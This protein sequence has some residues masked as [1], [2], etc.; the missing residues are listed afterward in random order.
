MSMIQIDWTPDRN[1]LRQFA[2]IWLSGFSLIG[3]LFAWKLGCFEGTQA[4]TIPIGL[5]TAAG[6]VGFLGLAFPTAVKPVYLLWMAVTFPIGWLLS[7]TILAIIYFAIFGV[8]GLVFRLVG[9]DAL[10]LRG[11]ADRDTYWVKRS[12]PASGRRYFQQF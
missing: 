7:H 10:G 12:S 8:L 11:R 2:L 5:W 9:R 3:L 6:V 1:K 4:W